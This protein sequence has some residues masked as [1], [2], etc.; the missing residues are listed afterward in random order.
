M[1][2]KSKLVNFTKSK[3]KKFVQDIIL[4]PYSKTEN[5]YKL[6]LD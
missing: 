6:F 1:L 5:Y 4:L 3:K 2:Y